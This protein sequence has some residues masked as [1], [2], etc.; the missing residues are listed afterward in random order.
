MRTDYPAA[1]KPVTIWL[2]RLIAWGELMRLLSVFVSGCLAWCGLAAPAMAKPPLAAFGDMPAVRSPD[3]SADGKHVAYI[4]RVDGVD[5]LAKYEVA[6][7]KNEAL[8]RLPD[9]KA[10]GAYW[11]GSNY[12]ILLASKVTTNSGLTKRYE[13]TSAFAYNISTR[14]CRH[15]SQMA[16]AA[17]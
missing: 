8:I 15:L 10:L 14:A 4:S 6:T 13:D 5:Y 12:V 17:R 1:Q 3:I 9:V 11:V 7:G 2:D 16:A